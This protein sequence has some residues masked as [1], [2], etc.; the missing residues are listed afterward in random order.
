MSTQQDIYAAG[1][2]NRPPM[3]NKD[4]YVPWSS[5]LLCYTK[6]KP[7]RKLN[8]KSIM[9]GPYVKRMIPEPCDPDR[10]DIG[11]QE[12][13]DKLFNEWER[14]TSTDG[15]SIESYYHH[16]LKL[17]ND[18]KRNK[19]FPKKIANNLKFLNNLQPEWRRH[20][21]IIHQTK[22]LHEVDYTRLYDFLKFNQVEVRCYNCRGIGHLA[23]NCTI[24]PRRRDAAYLQTQLL[25]AQKEGA[26]IQLQAEEF[27]LMAAAGDIDEIEEVNPNC[28]L[29]A[30][31]QQASTSEEQY[32]E[33]L[34]PIHEPHQVQQNDSNVISTGSS[35]EQSGGTVDQ[36]PTIVE[37]TP[38]LYDSLYNN[39]AIG[40]RKSTRSRE[41][42][43]FS[44]TSKMAS[45]S[46]SILK[47]ISIPNEE[48]S[49]DTSSSVARKLL[50]EVKKAAKFVRDFK[51][52]V[53]EADESLA[54]H[55][56]LE[57]KIERLLRVVVSQ[58][59]KSIV[60]NP[61]VL[62]TF[63]LQTE[64]E[65]QLGDLKGKNKDTPCVSDTFDPLSQKLEDE[66][67][68]LE[69]Q[70]HKPK[71]KKPK[72]L[73][74]KGKLASPKPSKPR[75][76]LR[77]SPTGRI[78]DLKGKIIASS[79]FEHQ[80]VCSKGENACTSNPQEPTSKR[81]PNSAFSLAGRPNLFMVRQLG[82]P[83][84]YD[85]KSKASHK[86]RLEVSGNLSLWKLSYYL[87]VAFRRNTCFARNLEGV[88]LLKGNRTTN[89]YT[90]NLHEITPASPI[91]LM[92]RATSTNMEKAKRHHP[93]KPVPNSKQRLHLLHM[94][95]C[96]PMRV[97]SING[98]RALCYPKNDR[99]DIGK[100]GAKG[101][102]LTYAPSTIT[103]QKT[104]ERE[105]D[106]IF[107]A[108]YDDYIGGQPSAAT[109]T[110]PA[111]QA[112]Q[113]LQTPTSS[114]TIADI[115]STPTNSPSHVEDTPNISHDVNELEQHVQQQDD[116]A[117]L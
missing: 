26:G 17:M 105:L 74:S 84:A 52:L 85:R 75:T 58:D 41:E 57:Y 34:E 95:L 103:S 35:V 45:V 23:R 90:I 42:L 111:A 117:Q 68:E 112:P 106:L 94:D 30:N 60:Q 38:A 53:K 5:R 27:I 107:E 49:N 91:C 22:D 7:N 102:D 66:N 99:E 3:L 43:Y 56:A 92:A 12:K 51:S 13:K 28:I 78:F 87:K 25:I 11:I 97:K 116:Q 73:G 89:L 44:N 80:S 67:V 47:S 54:K 29:V 79:E 114:T 32:I 100:L 24:R 110:A 37:E 19:H 113:V 1:F 9:N 61:T 55:K 82:V 62:E 65:P 93:P 109:R 69:F 40:L 101:L 33:L 63:D 6:S 108:M 77:W 72:K 88:D 21:T 64:L 31:L 86:F 14:F 8:Y 50:N 4:N 10:S 20:V 98:K 71:A 81:F 16:F 15:E 39:L 76:Y 83:K 18:F 70:K 59:I 104:T 2:E 115:T 36:H 48:F 96:G 46:N